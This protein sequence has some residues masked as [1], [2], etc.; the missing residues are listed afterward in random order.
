MNKKVLILIFVLVLC[1]A[2]FTGCG[3]NQKVFDFDYKYTKALVCE[4]GSWNEYS[5]EKW[6]DYD[7]DMICIWTTDSKMIY[8]SSVNVVLYG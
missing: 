3:C 7:N 4:A 6:S 5:I 8:T 1:V 2:C